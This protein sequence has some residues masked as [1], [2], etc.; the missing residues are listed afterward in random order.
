MAAVNALARTT[1]TDELD[2]ADGLRRRPGGDRLH[3]DSKFVML[4]LLDRLNSVC[5][6]SPLK[7]QILERPGLD[8]IL[9]RLPHI[10]LTLNQSLHLVIITI[11]IVLH[12][13]LDQRPTRAN[14][15]K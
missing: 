1:L 14:G 4:A 5:L 8:L 7:W 11:T 12:I 9:D 6:F 15:N 13:T 10:V 2:G 3:D